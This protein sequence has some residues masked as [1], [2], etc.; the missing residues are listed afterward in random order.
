MS[1]SRTRGP[2]LAPGGRSSAL[3]P[4]R[5]GGADGGVAAPPEGTRRARIVF[6]G[7]D[8][9]ARGG[10]AQFGANLVRSVGGRAETS[11][12]SYRRLYLA[13]PDPDG[14][15]PIRAGLDRGSRACRSSFHGGRRPGARR[16]RHSSAIR[17]TWW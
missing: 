14:R 11:I 7:V 4:R 12:L 6:V 13:S 1:G 16:P 3:R 10:I 8:P 17:R 15:D 5:R 2:H 9:S